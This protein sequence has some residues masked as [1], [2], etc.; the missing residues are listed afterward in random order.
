MAFPDKLLNRDEE[1]ILDLRP[2]WIALVPPGLAVAA[3]V[4]LGIVAI[5]MGWPA[6][7]GYPVGVA[8]LVAL[9]YFGIRYLGWTTTNF[10]ITSER[11]ITRE[12]FI[13]KRGKEIPLDKIN[14]VFFSQTVF[15][16]M[17]GSGDLAIESAGESGRQDFSN[18]RKPNAVQQEIYNQID[19]IEDRRMSRQAEE[20]ARQVVLQQQALGN[21]KSSRGDSIPEQIA[22]LN[23]LR[24]QGIISSAE[25]AQKKAELLDRM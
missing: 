15:E 23:D 14:G 4:L 11:F 8:I 7:V 16:R 10:V 6:G 9:I 17:I 24:Q 25:F 12:G 21:S 13:A 20:G 19:L 1:L 18:V 5:G 3:T 2:H 22:Q